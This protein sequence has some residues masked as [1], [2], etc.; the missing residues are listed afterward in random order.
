MSN[1]LEDED[2]TVRRLLEA[3]RDG[4]TGTETLNELLS[5]IDCIVNKGWQLFDKELL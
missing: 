4:R 3:A 2:V 5:S 1:G